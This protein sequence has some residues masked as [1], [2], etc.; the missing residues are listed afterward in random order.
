MTSATP[1]ASVDAS[2]FREYDIRGYVDENFTTPVLGAIGRAYGTFLAAL[3]RAGAQGPGPGTVAVGRDVRLSSARFAAAMIEGLRA[4]GADV[5]DIGMVPTPLVY[6]AV[7]TLR[8]DA[9]AC[10]T[11]SH[12]PPAFNGLKLRKR[13][14]ALPNGLPLQPSE[15]QEVRRLAQEGAFRAAPGG[16]TG[17]LRQ[18]DVRDAYVRY[19]GE[20]ITLSR[21]LKVVV[22]AG[23]GAAGPVAVRTL[24]AIGCEVIPLYCDPDGSFPNHMPDPLRPENLRDLIARVTETGADLGIALDGDGDRLGV[25]DDSGK[26]LEA[27]RYLI[28]LARSVLRNGRPGGSV[29]FDVKCSMALSEQIEKMGGVPVMSR[30]GYPN[31]MARRREVDALLAG[32]L[33]GHIFF[34]DPTIDFDDGTF[35]AANL[36]QALAREEVPLSRIVAD[37]PR[38]YS[39]PEERFFCPDDQKFDV[40]AGLRDAFR[41]DP[42]VQSIFDLDGARVSF[43]GGWGLVRA[44]NTEPALTTRFEAASPERMEEIRQDFMQRLAGIPAVDLTRSGH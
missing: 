33:S 32:E 17:S 20:R 22:D 3:P 12:N 2:M 43:E 11:A 42:R 26:I 38:Y 30:T 1:A 16:A 14:P 29:V 4:T 39:T 24:E 10:I 19:V 18:E 27:D 40:V 5:V 31:I 37:L 7:N 9:G 28:L 25:V 13:D 23:N 35:A 15:V 44:S 41:A 8:T 34:N 6:F 21:R 36:L